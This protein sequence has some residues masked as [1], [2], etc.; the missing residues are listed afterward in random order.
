METIQISVRA[1]VEFLLRSGDLDNRRGGWA[2]KEAMQ[3]GSRIHRKI[4]KRMGSGYM[5]EYPLIYEKQFEHY[6]LKIEGRADGIF[7]E[8]GM[9][10][11]DEIKSTYAPLEH[12]E[13]PLPVHIAQAKCYAY[14]YA[15]Q[16]HKKQ[17]R[18][19]MTYCN[20]ETEDIRRFQEEYTMEELDNWFTDLTNQY[21]KWAE[22]QYQ[23]RLKRDASMQGLE[24]P[25]PYREGQKKL[26]SDVYRTILR[27]KELF[28]NAPTG[29]GKTLS[30]LFPA[31]RAVGEK[32]GD[33]IFYL[34]A[35]TITRTVAEEAFTT[36]KLHGLV[37]KVITLTA[38]EKMCVC[39][40]MECNPETCERAK[41]HYDRVNDAVF[42]LLNNCDTF[43][44]DILLEAAQKAEVCPY[45]FQLDL[46]TWADAVICDY[47]YVFDPVVHLR[48]FFGEGT[49]KGE[50][51]F[52]IDEAH[53]L[54]ERGR[55]MYSASVF[56]EDFLEIKRIIKPYTLHKK[57]TNALER[58]N[59]QLLGYKRECS[60]TCLELTNVG[61]FVI[62][63]M[64]LLGELEKFLQDYKE[65]AHRK[66][67]L[68]FYFSVR[69]FV[70]IYELLDENY[71]IYAMH[72]EEGRF[73][74]KLFCV[75]PAANLQECLNKGRS[76][77]F[78]SATLLPIKYY[79]KLFSTNT[80]DYAVYV[81]SP[82][83]PGN[84][85]LI[86][87]RDVSTRYTRRGM[88]EYTRIA[89][90]ISQTVK[91]KRGNYMAFFPSYRMMEDVYHIFCE[92]FL[93]GLEEDG[94]VETP[95]QSS[96]MNERE[97]EE[98]LDAFS[99]NG[100]QGES[101]IG[102]CVMG[103]IFSE[104]IDLDGEQLIGAIVVGTGIPQLSVERE[105]LKKFYDRRG[106]NGFDYAYRYP[107]MNKVLQSAGRVIRTAQD[108]GVVVLLDERFLHR[109][110]LNLFPTEWS[111]YTACSLRTV[112][113]EVRQFWDGETGCAT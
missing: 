50:H 69:S 98:F 97:R 17:M 89:S 93:P 65:G 48:R 81:G 49:G 19:Q 92:S 55:E 29:V 52:L 64:N 24:F 32:K 95:L 34:T 11:I 68:E 96:G 63:M 37:Y 28:V 112:A 18:V 80:D 56:K 16:K 78:F 45:E 8:D 57:L 33:K 38:K 106:E 60:E 4:Q 39:E 70:N 102:F 91:Q 53:N 62:S 108:K 30:T 12:L 100:G 58:C 101:L 3:K 113:G 109:E 88:E 6:I 87:G 74:L 15:L 83:E 71:M 21:H 44:R 14:I 23:W 42:E 31:V 2:D 5:A 46:A 51:L 35:K 66:K 20:L 41:G 9:D 27:K 26:V 7:S 73:M 105:L 13:E 47:N 72:T 103:G 10:V 85:K 79:K 75:N 110:Y 59:R 90:Y 61:E 43:S 94:K 77:V 22:F 107:G 82:F 25:Y 76:A 67:I 1:L 104:G 36:L 84:R 111:N 86:L 99:G 54:V 40:E